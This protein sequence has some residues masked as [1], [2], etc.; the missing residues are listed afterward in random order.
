MAPFKKESANV[1]GAP[2]PGMEFDVEGPSADHLFDTSEV[3]NQ[4]VYQHVLVNNDEWELMDEGQVKPYLPRREIPVSVTLGVEEKQTTELYTFGSLHLPNYFQY[5]KGYVLN[6]GSSIWGLDFVPKVSANESD[7]LTQYLAVSGYRGCAEERVGMNDLQPTGSYKN[8]IQI[9]KLKLSTKTQEDPLLDLCILHDYGVVFDLKWCPYGAY[10]EEKSDA[11]GAPTTLPKL[12]ILSFSC[13]DGTLRT[14]VVPHPASVRK[15]M[16]P[17]HDPLKPVFLRI[18]SSRC[19]FAVP[20]GRVLKFAWGGH[21]KIAAGY[22]YGTITIWNM[23]EALKENN[24]ILT[25]QSK[26]LIQMSILAFY[27]SVASLS[28]NGVKDPE[29]L[30]AGGFDGQIKVIDT[31][32][33]E[34]SYNAAR[35]RNVA[36]AVA[37]AHR[38]APFLYSDTEGICRGASLTES[39]TPI[40]SKYC[41]APGTAW[42]IATSEH[43]GQFVVGTSFG[44]TRGGNMYQIRSR[45]F[46]VKQIT[47]YKLSYSEITKSYRYIDGIGYQGLDE[48]RKIPRFQQFGETPMAIQKIIWN[49]NKPTCAFLASGGSAGLCRIEFEGRGTKWD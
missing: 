2:V 35:L 48:T 43:H 10:E 38:D 21:K 19:T 15:H 34:I 5:K 41:D 40:M 16:V 30:I 1:W 25:E 17:N 4:V 27:C 22:S 36:T 26:R 33:P 29:F 3:Y 28:W 31:K 49:P 14:I 46:T 39:Y 13:G 9:W 18:K 47:V 24:T 45:S 6:T 11:A 23:E 42:D 7:P 32:D 37:W 8:C 20:T 12:G 44:W